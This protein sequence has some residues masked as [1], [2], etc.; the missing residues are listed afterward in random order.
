MS[1]NQTDLF[2]ESDDDGY[3]NLVEPDYNDA[4]VIKALASLNQELNKYECRT[5]D[6]P[7]LFER[8]IATYAGFSDPA[9]HFPRDGCNDRGE[10]VEV[11]VRNTSNHESF[12][13][14]SLSQQCPADV[15]VLA[16]Y[17]Q[18]AYQFFVLPGYELNNHDGTYSVLARPT[19]YPARGGEDRRRWKV[20][21]S[22]LREEV[23]K[24]LEKHREVR[25]Y[26]R[27]SREFGSFQG[28]PSPHRALSGEQVLEIRK[29][30]AT[31][32]YRQVDLAEEY[33]LAEPAIHAL[34]RGYSYSEVG[35][36]IVE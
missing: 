30:Y 20:P 28:G 35:G 11:K 1:R 36:P 7:R 6:F 13:Y 10:F 22:Q 27:W 23:D 33:D 2:E 5:K 8:I 19:K 16:G 26:E 32:N 9:P 24:A 31:G 25:D 15:F 3:K 12:H 29:K 18:G 17:F 4:P 14:S 34:I 21:A